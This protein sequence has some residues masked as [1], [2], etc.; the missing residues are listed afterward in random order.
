MSTI[1]IEPFTFEPAVFS[2]PELKFLLDHV[3]EPPSAALYGTMPPGV[4][5][6]AIEQ[7]LTQLHDLQQLQLHRNVPWAGF[8]VVKDSILRYLS[9]D[10]K[11]LEIF[12]MT[13]GANGQNAVPNASQYEWGED[14]SAYKFAIG[15]DS[16]EMPR[17]EI[18]DDGTRQ[19][20]A[21]KLLQPDGE[22][23]VNALGTVAPWIKRGRQS[24]IAKSKDT[25]DVVK[26]GKHGH[27]TCSVCGKAE[28]FQTAMRSS[29]TAARGRMAK[30]LKQAKTETSRHRLLYRM[31]FE[32]RTA[33]L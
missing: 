28:E 2:I 23:M 18:L 19:P 4:N 14:G 3:E 10:E 20:F 25:V 17:T 6:V 21:V 16:A 15:A 33:K 26:K 13:G 32:S 8:D 29:F 30:H 22:A 9:W 24:A 5:P 1:R 11:R 31:V 12:R 27:I 7:V